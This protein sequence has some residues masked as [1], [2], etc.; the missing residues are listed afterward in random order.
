MPDSLRSCSLSDFSS[1]SQTCDVAALAAQ[2]EARWRPGCAGA[3][4]GAGTL[5]SEVFASASDGA[6]AGLAL[7]LARDAM[8]VAD[9]SGADDRMIMWVQDRRAARLSGKPYRHGLPKQWRDRVIY[10]EAETCEDALFAL[11]EGL[12]CRELALVLG[13]VSGNPRALNFTAS[14]RLSLASERYGVPLW[15]VRLDARP[16]L[17]S[18]RMRWSAKSGP[19]SAAPWDRQAPGAPV[20][21]AELF[22][23]RNHAPG[24][25]DLY[26][27][28]GQL[29]LTERKPAAKLSPKQWVGNAFVRRNLVGAGAIPPQILPEPLKAAS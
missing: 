9:L 15:L 25:W 23:A 4:A 2:R 5:H 10:V 3:G 8:R 17:S 1:L 14:R 28:A 7:A 12:R 24:K 19:S 16:D 20:W 22:R 27:D 11:E 29:A 21:Q 18:A 13:E 6:G 26:E